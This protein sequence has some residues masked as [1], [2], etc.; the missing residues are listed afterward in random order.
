MA[1]CAAC[2]SGRIWSA[3]SS[4]RPRAPMRP[5]EALLTTGLV[6]AVPSPLAIS[7]NPIVPTR[8]LMAV[9]FP[10]PILR[11]PMKGAYSSRSE[12]PTPR[13]CSSSLRGTEAETAEMEVGAAGAAARAVAEA[14]PA[15]ESEERERI[16]SWFRSTQI[17]IFTAWGGTD[18]PSLL[19]QL[20]RV[21]M[22]LFAPAM[23]D[24]TVSRPTSN[25][26]KS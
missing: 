13:R 16:A 23:V 18:R 4:T 6:I 5:H 25:S 17:L 20:P 22:T 11:L 12:I 9:S 21:T 19:S 10:P 2:S 26:S 14:H 8:A 24:F 1:S 15:A 3:V 7:T